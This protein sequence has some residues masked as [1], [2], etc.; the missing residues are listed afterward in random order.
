MFIFASSV[1]WMENYATV[2]EKVFIGV[3]MALLGITIVV[4]VLALISLFVS[5]MSRV[6]NAGGQ[7]G[8]GGQTGKVTPAEPEEEEVT[9]QVLPPEEADGQ[10]AGQ[11]TLVAVI[12]AAVAAYMA[13]D[14]PR[15]SAGFIIRRVRRV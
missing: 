9:G 12:T 6:I 5:L 7:R 1:P 8:P 15:S 2:T 4:V 11:Q 14:T 10:E 13:D 3:T